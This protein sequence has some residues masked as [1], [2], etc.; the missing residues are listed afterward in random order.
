VLG[1]ATAGE[2]GRWSARVDLVSPLEG[3]TYRLVAVTTVPTAEGTAEMLSE[4]L[5]VRFSTSGVEPVSITIDNSIADARGR[6]V[7]WDPRTGNAA[8]TLVY[9]PQVPMKLTARFEDASRVRDF[10]AYVGSLSA[11]GSCTATECSAT[12]PPANASEVGDISVGYTVDALPVTNGSTRVPTLEEIVAATPFPFN[13]PEDAVFEV[14]GPDEFTGRWTVQG[15]PLE[16]RSTIGAARTLGEPSPEDLALTAAI[17]APVRN[18]SI[19]KRGEG[20]D[21]EL[22]IS[23]DM[24]ASWLSSGAAGRSAT[25]SLADSDWKK[26]EKA[27]KVG[28]AFKDLLEIA[29]NGAD[30]AVLDRLQDHVDLNI[31]ACQ[32]EIAAELTG[33]IDDAKGTLVLHKLA[34]NA[35]DW[36]TN[37]GGSFASSSADP[38]AASA[39][40]TAVKQLFKELTDRLGQQFIDRAIE[41]VEAV[42]MESCDPRI[43]FKPKDFKPGRPV[44]SPTWIYDPSGYVYEALGT[45]RLEGVTATVLRG[46]SAEGPWTVWDAEAFGQTNPQSTSVEGAYGWDVPQGWWKVRYEKEGYRTAESEPLQVLPEHYGV[47]IDLHRLA[48]PALTG[49]TATADGAV[50]VVFDQWMNT[51]SVRTALSVR[52][53]GQPVAGSVTPVGQ[54]DSPKGVAL[55]RTFRFVPAAP[56][57]SGQQLTVT[58]PGT[59]VDHG[60]VPLGTDAVRTVT[61]PTRPDGQPACGMVTTAVSPTGRVKSG[62][63]LTVTVTAAPGVP[64]ELR[65]LTA[66]SLIDW[67]RAVLTGQ[68][69]VAKPW[70][71]VGTGTTGANGKATFTYRATADTLL[72]GRQPGCRSLTGVAVVDVK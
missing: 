29:R 19:T 8:P 39:I 3:S 18:V 32:P 12:F 26:V 21:A 41:R 9:V 58:V 59:V 67:L 6:A 49:A 54:L 61:A 5:E 68:A 46:E 52:A 24:S 16:V 53:G 56:F 4:P 35:L 36:M 71:V 31:L 33:Y 13:S 45:Q 66:P 42:G 47:D 44:G 20:E 60:G 64:V 10:T 30:S 43:K 27:I 63:N 62:T 37:A 40:N 38:R 51:E 2:G 7:T 25:A 48:P 28:A 23:A 72:H 34:A 17:G 55:A 50:E 11:E 70:K 65:A 14:T 57:G 1:T 15:M 69:D 22:V